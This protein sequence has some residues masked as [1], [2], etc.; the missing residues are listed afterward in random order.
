MNRILVCDGAISADDPIHPGLQL[1]LAQNVID[2]LKAVEADLHA[3]LDASK[4][5][6]HGIMVSFVLREKPINGG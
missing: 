2:K 1:P 3:T 5:G 6:Q 4:A